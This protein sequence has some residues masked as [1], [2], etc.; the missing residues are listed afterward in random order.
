MSRKKKLVDLKPYERCAYCFRKGITDD[1]IPPKS[2]FGNVD[3]RGLPSVR[4]CKQC[5]VGSSVDDEYFKNV[6]A[7][8]DGN[9]FTESEVLNK[10]LSCLRDNKKFCRNLSSKQVLGFTSSNLYVGP[11]MTYDIDFKIVHKVVNRITK[12]L[13]KFTFGNNVPWNYNVS[14]QMISDDYKSE[15]DHEIW[16]AFNKNIKTIRG[17]FSYSYLTCSDAKDVSAWFLNFYQRTSFYCLICNKN[18]EVY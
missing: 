3:K 16:S 13:F 14:T 7:M 12:G 2:I 1:H 5:N 8:R 11:V 9:K 6:L 15:G 17:M 18:R 4:S 10:T